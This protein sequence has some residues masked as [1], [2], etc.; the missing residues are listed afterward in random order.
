MRRSCRNP[1]VS[2]IRSG[3]AVNASKLPSNRLTNCSDS[4]EMRA[5]RLAIC[6]R[7]MSGVVRTLAALLISRDGGCV[8][9]ALGVGV[10]A[11]YT[12]LRLSGLFR[13]TATGVGA[14]AGATPRTNSP[15]SETGVWPAMS[16]VNV[17]EVTFPVGTPMPRAPSERAFERSSRV[18]ICSIA[19][20]MPKR[21]R[22]CLAAWNC[23][24]SS[25][26]DCSGCL[27]WPALMTDSATP[28]LGNI[29]SC[30]VMP[31]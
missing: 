26:R 8:P 22:T 19:F 27:P 15:V 29:S 12:R 13:S 1:A 3:S 24:T 11:P 16:W 5:G 2:C 20:C 30:S 28:V 7:R 6:L 25:C 31:V 21:S 23:A 17:A 4:G 9:T 10:P 18:R 14:T